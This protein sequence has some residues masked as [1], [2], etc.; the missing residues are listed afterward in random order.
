M[1]CINKKADGW[2]CN[3]PLFIDGFQPTYFQGP[4]IILS[5]NRQQKKYL[6]AML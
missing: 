3:H 5:A 1:L 6:S 4:M 2:Y